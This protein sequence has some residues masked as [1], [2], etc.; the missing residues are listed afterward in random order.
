[1]ESVQIL[2][3]PNTGAA[4]DLR[5]TEFNE[6]YGVILVAQDLLFNR[7]VIQ[8][9]EP[10]LK[11]ALWRYPGQILDIIICTHIIVREDLVY[12][13]APLT[14]EDLI[15]Q[16]YLLINA[17]LATMGAFFIVLFQG[18]FFASSKVKLSI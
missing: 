17:W 7:R 18:E 4:V 13:F 9:T 5:N 2:Q 3:Q 8:K 1:M 16:F 14:T 6:G 10:T 11:M 15:V 12:Q